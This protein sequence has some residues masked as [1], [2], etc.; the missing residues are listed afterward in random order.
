MR[1]SARILLA[2]LLPV[3][4]S[5]SLLISSASA[6]TSYDP[7]SFAARLVEL[8]NAAR[9]DHG[10]V[11]LKLASGTTTVAAGWTQQ[12][13]ADQRLSHNPD[14]QAQLEAHGSKDWTVL[15]ENVGDSDTQDPDGLFAAYMAS[16]E[17]RENV[18][19][20]KFRYLGNAVL[21]AGGRAWNTMDFVDAYASTTAATAKPAPKAAVKAAPA[22]VVA[23]P[24]PRRAVAPASRAARPAPAAQP[25]KAAPSKPLAVIP[26]A[27]PVVEAAAATAAVLPAA[28]SV[29]LPSALPMDR[30]RVL[31]LAVA[32]ML[33][34]LL[35]GAW[36]GVA[37]PTRR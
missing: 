17:H 14:L 2:A 27:K 30:G 7:S 15:G 12:L 26:V 36:V 16:P 28:P 21:F 22:P 9:Q 1:T 10:L 25:R 37:L 23:A 34:L 24:A 13:A 4:L 11:P 5:S 33:A 3:F 6:S 31:A 29:T 32:A 8:L 18:L 35:G 19:T 20:A